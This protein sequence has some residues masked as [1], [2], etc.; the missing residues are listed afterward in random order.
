MNDDVST[1]VTG[2][3]LNTLWRVANVMLPQVTNAYKYPIEEIHK[4]NAEAKDDMYGKVHPWWTTV[5][6]LLERA[7]FDTSASLINTQYALNRAVDAY[8]YVDGNNAKDLTKVGQ[9]LEQIIKREGGKD[10]KIESGL[11]D[12]YT[13][14]NFNQPD[15]WSEAHEDD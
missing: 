13:G 9:E 11:P 12:G 15:S 8:A 7:M 5:G 4:I 1:S 6:C 3:D 2:G 14:P 10:Q